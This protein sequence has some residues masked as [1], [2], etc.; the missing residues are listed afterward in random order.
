MK[1]GI[2]QPYFFPY[3]GYFDVINRSDQWVIF[4]TPQYIRHGWMNRN[5][6]LHPQKG[7]Q[8]IIVPLKKHSKVTP[9]TEIE[10]LNPDALQ[11]RILGQLAHYKKKAPFFKDTLSIVEKCLE[12]PHRHLTRLNVH[13][14]KTVCSYLQISFD[15]IYFSQCNKQIGPVNTPGDWAFEI[16]KA[17]GA[18]EYI[19][20]PGGTEL[21][22]RTKFHEAGVKLTITNLIDLTYDC[23]GYEFV[24]H[25]SIIDVLMWN[26]PVAVKKYLDS[27]KN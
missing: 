1:I 3:L 13:I 23:P 14:L 15:H 17:F 2:M 4:D 10:I 25:L 9:L 12:K 8:Y 27:L 11:P 20:P 19:N 18:R 7:W 22:D 5:R 26:H 16:C 21:F 6:I 24:S